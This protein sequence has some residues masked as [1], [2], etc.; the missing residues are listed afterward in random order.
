[1]ADCST[2]HD[3]RQHFCRLGVSLAPNRSS[4]SSAVNCL[5]SSTRLAVDLLDQHRGR[6]LADAAAV[7]VEVGVADRARRASIASSTRTTSP[8][9]GLS[10]SCACVAAGSGRDE[11]A[12]RSD[13][14]C[15]PGTVRLRRAAW[16]VVGVANSGHGD[17]RVQNSALPPCQQVSRRVPTGGIAPETHVPTCRHRWRPRGTRLRA[18]TLA[19]PRALLRQPVAVDLGKVAGAALLHELDQVLLVLVGEV[20]LLDLVARGSGSGGHPWRTTRRLPPASSGCRRACRGAESAT[21][22]IVGV[23]KAPVSFSSLVTSTRPMSGFSASMP[24]PRLWYFSSVRLAPTWQAEQLP[25]SVKNSSR[26]RL[27]RVRHR[28]RLRRRPWP[29]SYLAFSS[30][31][32]PRCLPGR[33][34]RRAATARS[35]R[36]ARGR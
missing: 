20:E 1:M 8:Q 14:G 33:A 24:T 29:A 13:P 28:M 21:L 5:T 3:S 35:S 9:S 22:R 2:R 4:M 25:L 36:T 32:R 17:Q 31:R 16:R 15:A 12:L 6:G 26:P 30:G 18:D 7:A 23:L 34:S 10:S 11:T 27:A 19:S